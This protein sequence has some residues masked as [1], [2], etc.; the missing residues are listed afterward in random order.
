MYTR[1]RSAV[2]RTSKD[3]VITHP[4]ISSHP[5]T[6]YTTLSHRP[7]LPG[8]THHTFYETHPLPWDDGWNSDS[9]HSLPTSPL[10]SATPTILKGQIVGLTQHTF[11][12]THP[13][14]EMLGGILKAKFDTGD[15]KPHVCYMNMAT[16][17]KTSVS[18]WRVD[19]THN[20]S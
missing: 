10:T 7:H 12:E 3:K 17:W 16:L 11:S 5:F 18:T 1:S 15:P 2:D 19:C 20:L 13:N 4:Y 14:L 6:S 9:T 8:L